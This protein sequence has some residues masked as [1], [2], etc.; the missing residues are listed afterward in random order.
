MAAVA[1][2]VIATFP[3]EQ[4]RQAY[5][6]WLRDGHVD[7][8]IRAGAHTGSILVITEPAT[9]LEVHTRYI[10]SNA[11]TLDRYLEHHAPALR[12]DGLRHFGPES[13][14]TMRRQIG[15]IQ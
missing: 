3:D 4:T 1:Y 2:T 5:I 15:T 9:P 12:A 11:D 8:V 10:F 6:A 13:G 7:A 14:V